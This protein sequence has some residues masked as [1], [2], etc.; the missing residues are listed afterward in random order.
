MT[1]GV[2]AGT[3]DGPV[4]SPSAPAPAAATLAA[5][6]SDASAWLLPHVRA[7]LH[8]LDDADVTPVVRRLRAA[9]TSRLAGG[10]IRRE[11]DELLAAGGPTWQALVERLRGR[12]DLPAEVAP[13]LAAGDP[14]A[15]PDPPA[16]APGADPA[17]AS[18]A[19]QER[20]A[21]RARDRLRQVLAERDEL[22]R[23]LTGATA[24]ATA[25]EDEVA[26]ARADLRAAEERI[27]DLEA[28]RRGAA[29]ERDRAVERE[30]RRRDG[31]VARLE[32]TIVELRRADEERRRAARRRDERERLARDAARR[33]VTEERRAAHRA[34]APTR[35][36]PGRPS[37]LPADVRPGTTE[38]A[39]LL[40]HPGR[41]VLV[42]GY[43]VTKQHQPELDLE[44]QRA[45]LVRTLATLASRRRVRPTAVF[46]GRRAAGTRP[47]TGGREVAVVFTPEG[48]TADDE[49]VL[50]VEATDEPVVV[51]T[52]DR[53]LAG[54]L[55]AS[56]ADVLGTRPF[57]G[58]AR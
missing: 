16:R 5:L 46:D 55:A 20:T 56:G 21:A 49:L 36:V 14:S 7:A 39:E 40:L 35:L 15:A 1:P 12:T 45:W 54:R 53:E 57:L 10:R 28:A 17:A 13:L 58:V 48:V 4:P 23:Q 22:R 37:R 11:L 32:A 27:R 31:E 8:D 24:R 6:S 25:A 41:L 30:R 33:Q 3:G 50:A 38:A 9:P 44:G 51:V 19:A 34:A 42:D 26:R 43:N 47:A 18:A 29:D 52:D 2:G